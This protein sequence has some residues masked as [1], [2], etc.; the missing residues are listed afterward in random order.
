M[1]PETDISYARGDEPYARGPSRGRNATV[2]GSAGLP[3]TGHIGRRQLP[4]TRWSPNG[5]DGRADQLRGFS[6]ISKVSIRSP[7]LMSW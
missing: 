4:A 6:T 5:A 7:I 3:G 2:P 1:T